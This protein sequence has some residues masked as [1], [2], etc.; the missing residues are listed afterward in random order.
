MNLTEP[1]EL[2]P[3]LEAFLLASGK[4]QSLER[5]F[6]LFEEAE[7]P[8]PPVFKKALEILRKSC[9]GRAFELREVASGY[10]LQIR[11]KFS[12]WVGRL[13]EER[14]Q[15]YSRAML[16]TMALI[17]YRQPITRG[18]IED[19]RGVAVNSHIVK[20][21]LEREWIRIV[22]YRDVPGKPAMFATTKVFLD[23]F[24][25]KNLDDLP[26]LAELREIEAEPVLDFD[27]APVPAG[28]QE[29]ADASAEPEEPKDETSFHTL[30][31]ELDD[32]EQGIKT[33]FDDLL[34]D[35]AAEPETPVNVETTPAVEPEPLEDILGVA[36]AREKL[37]AA[38]AA[39]EQPELSEEEAEARALAE[40]IENER[41]EFE[42]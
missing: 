40:A 13:W 3:L 17:A 10:R 12:P 41:R 14:P 31:L 20:T 5:L 27:D 36:A 2:A 32:M 4:P 8:E 30:L 11:E 7:R 22:G 38:V 39:L 26:P 9:E 24:N 6:E 34:R 29:L 18:E 35:G 25:L 23:H 21:L 1:R 28:L 19:V 37:L 15:R 16:E 42:D 33:D